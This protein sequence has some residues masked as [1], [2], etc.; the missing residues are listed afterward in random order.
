MYDNHV[1]TVIHQINKPWK[2]N[3]WNAG[4]KLWEG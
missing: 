4:K 3:A 1:R 2:K